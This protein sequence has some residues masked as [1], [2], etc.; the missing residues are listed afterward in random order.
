M[1][2][3][4]LLQKVGCERPDEKMR[5]FELLTKQVNALALGNVSRL[6]DETKLVA[7]TLLNTR[8]T[9]FTEEEN[10]EIIKKISSEVY[11]H[12]RAINRD[13]ARDYIGLKQVKDA[14]HDKV[15]IANQLWELYEQYKL[16]FEFENAFRPEQELAT[17]DLAEKTWPNLNI[18][19]VESLN[20]FD[21][22]TTDLRVRKMLQQLPQQI[23]VN[24]ANV[25]IPAINIS[26]LPQGIDEQSVYNLVR[27]VFNQTVSQYLAN[28]TQVVVQELIKSL[29]LKFERAD[30]NLGWKLLDTNHG[31]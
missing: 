10:H 25:N 9:P 7:S 16:L 19:C 24:L 18:A 2:Y 23:N 6:L 11:S 4:S 8:A 27:Q 28:A 1:G 31:D 29:P 20:R 30:L 21:V 5:G 12:Y 22:C 3:F 26:G 17:T 13:E 15:D 14:E